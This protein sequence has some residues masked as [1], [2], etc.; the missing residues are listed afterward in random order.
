MQCAGEKE[1]ENLRCPSRDSRRCYRDRIEGIR[2]RKTRMIQ[3]GS[4]S[5]WIG[6]RY[7]QRRRPEV[8]LRGCIL[9]RRRINHVYPCT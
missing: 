8:R 6:D 2:R 7:N 4:S 5:N 9:C 3:A 1:E